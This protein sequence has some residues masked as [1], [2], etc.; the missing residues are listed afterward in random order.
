MS[1]GNSD[2]NVG[3][4]VQSKPTF[5]EAQILDQ[6][7][8]G[9]E[10]RDA[11]GAVDISFSFY[12]SAPPLGASATQFVNGNTQIEVERGYAATDSEVAGFVGFNATQQQMTK[13]A[14]DMWSDVAN[15]NFTE[16]TSG[17][18]GINFGSAN[19]GSFAFSSSQHYVSDSTV[20]DASSGFF[21][22]S[23][24]G[25]MI[26]NDIWLS[27]NSSTLNA[28]TFGSYGFL[29]IL[30]EIGHALGLNH[31]GT[32]NGT[33][34]T[35]SEILYDQDSNQYT[36]MSYN[37]ARETGADHVGLNGDSNGFFDTNNNGFF[38]DA[39]DLQ[40]ED[41]ATTPLLHD[42]LAI[43]EIY[44][45]NMTTRTGDTT[46]GFN[47]NAGR[48]A[49]DFTINADPVVAIWDAGGIDTIDVSGF[50]DNQYLDL[51]DGA[52]SNVGDMTHNLAIA[53]GAIIENGTTGAGDDVLVGNAVDNVLRGGAGDDTYY[54]GVG[55]GADAVIDGVGADRIVFE[56]LIGANIAA[57]QDGDDL[58]LT[59]A[60]GAVTVQDYFVGGDFT[61]EADD[62]VITIALNAE[63]PP[64]VTTTDGLLVVGA[65]PRDFADFVSFA[66][67]NVD[68]VATHYRIQSSSATDTVLYLDGVAYSSTYFLTQRVLTAAEFAQLTIDAGD[69]GGESDL[70]TVAASDGVLW[71]A[72]VAVTFDTNAA[73][74]VT[75]LAVP[76]VIIGEWIDLED[77]FDL[78]DPD[79]ISD[80]HITYTVRLV[81]DGA[82]NFFLNVGSTVYS[83]ADFR[84]GVTLDWFDLGRAEVNA[85]T[86]GS[87][88]IE[89]NAFDGETSSGWT[90]ITLTAAL[91]S[92]PIVTDL[93]P[94]PFSHNDIAALDDLFSVSDAD[95][96]RITF[97][98]LE[99]V[100]DGD[101]N[102]QLV[103]SGSYLSLTSSYQLSAL[104]MLTAQL[105]F[106]G[107]GSD[108]LRLRAY[109][110]REWSEWTEITIESVDETPTLASTVSAVDV[111]S[112]AYLTADQLDLTPA[113]VDSSIF[114]YEF[115]ILN[116]A[117]TTAQV[118][119]GGVGYG[120]GVPTIAVP[121]ANLSSVFIVGLD[122]AGA[123]TLSV[124]VFD[125]STWSDPLEIV[126]NTIPPPTPPVVETGALA[127]DA[128]GVA[129]LADQVTVTDVNGDTPT[130]YD[131]YVDSVLYGG[132]VA[133]N[134][135]TLP[136]RT[137]VSLTA[138][139]FASLEVSAGSG[140]VTDLVWVRAFDGT[141]WS[142]WVNVDVTTTVPNVAPV[143]LSS[144]AVEIVFDQWIQLTTLGVGYTDDNPE[145]V[146]VEYEI[147]LQS[148]GTANTQFWYANTFYG[149]GDTIVVPASDLSGVYLGTLD[150]AGSDTL[151]IR[152]S[153]GDAWS[154]PVTATLSAVAPP[155][156]PV[157]ETGALALDANGV[158]MLADQVTV[159]DV[160]GDTPT[161][162]D[163]YVDSVLYGGS[164][165]LNGETLPPRTVV[166]LTASEFAS[167]EVSAG[168]GSVTDLV[169][170]RAFDGTFWSEWVN[171]DVTTT[172]PNVAPVALS[173][174][175][176][177][178][179][180][181]QWIQLTTLGVGYTDDNPEDVAVEY[182][183]TLQSDGTANTQ[184]WYANTFYGVG[185][186]IV[187]PAS[188]LSGVYLGTL[189][190]AGSDTLSIRVSDGDAWSAPVTA[191]LS[192]VAPPTPPVVE[193]SASIAA[194]SQG[195][196]I[197]YDS[198]FTVTDIN[199]DTPTWYEIYI[200][201]ASGL[202]AAG[203]AAGAFHYVMA[204]DFDVLDLTVADAGGNGEVWVRAYDGAFWSDW[205]MATAP[206]NPAMIAPLEE[207]FPDAA[208][209]EAMIAAAGMTDAAA[210]AGYAAV[211]D[212]TAYAEDEEDGGAAQS[213]FG[214]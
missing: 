142:E 199:G 43:Q 17:A 161:F 149:V 71:S 44:G 150:A 73:P 20:F 189:D 8:D 2:P 21:L 55:G 164:V 50:S 60:S 65:A 101:P 184:F 94:A 137:V 154:A 141:F 35:S 165:A 124:R 78:D 24:T 77:T 191:T 196:M 146:A 14:L 177:E 97:Y 202:E 171:V 194:V 126:V 135:E 51:N 116:D 169:W 58:V 134:G 26:Q 139:E 121:A 110:G 168:S 4:V 31:P 76:N 98:E 41:Y 91:N 205:T 12:A 207:G 95:G 120:A 96:H 174:S 100:N 155:T 203:Y 92:A 83:T 48:D 1:S 61:F 129:M 13:L 86:S 167:L 127:L 119:F 173:S 57:T 107:S 22:P 192:A 130:F 49:Y 54:F 148:D 80:F 38:G 185:D 145:D 11:S 187:V 46:Y 182:E 114:T 156:P 178:I 93:D 59:H 118:Y 160:N 175:A 117:A 70:F 9:Y 113:D 147:T 166:S 66:D 33:S 15:I 27:S 157:V 19:M 197:S 25:E 125:G 212:A 200:D 34:P 36:V 74:E 211:G 29:T 18:G 82:A 40:A 16:T 128:N 10:F 32:Y 56:G 158:A 186:T 198:L 23:N 195:D 37:D 210:M 72:D 62:G 180:F 176:V 30:H 140:S 87:D 81:D 5:T 39:G 102:A 88:V 183:I 188:D 67:A 79:R 204:D 151:S 214:V 152:V 28:P 190:A 115:T 170:V 68:D 75:A 69:E 105:D 112:G 213:G 52:F 132:S 84:D 153:D 131:V 3:S 136:P 103:V 109:D 90:P 63:I 6:L 7:I 208:L 111:V 89:V 106:M 163:V 42:I 133:L 53:N 64:V 85:L 122:G 45:A 143:A 138:S 47:S 108:T 193:A 162:Y 181:D 206:I 159:T 209:D 99:W 104:Q 123:D 172:V 201:P 144:S 179:V